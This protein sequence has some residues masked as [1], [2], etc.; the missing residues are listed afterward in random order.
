MKGMASC[1]GV[2]ICGLGGVYVGCAWVGNLCC[3]GQGSLKNRGSTPP[4]SYWFCKKFLHWWDK[5]VIEKINSKSWECIP[6][7]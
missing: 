7:L 2:C 5:F 1:Y 4:Q 6:N 3:I